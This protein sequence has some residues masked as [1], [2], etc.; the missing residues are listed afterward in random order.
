MAEASNGLVVIGENINTTRRIRAT[1]K[2]IVQEDGKV[3]WA[4]TGLDGTKR[5]LDITDIYPKD[6]K[7]VA[8]KELG[9]TSVLIGR[10]TRYR[11]REGSAAGASRAAS[12]SFDV[13]LH[14]APSGR[15]LWIGKFDE[16]QRPLSSGVFRVPS[17]P[18]GGTRW[19]SAEEMATWGAGEVA[20]SLTKTE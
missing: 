10:V 20:K 11:D 6:P 8:A 4:Y 2:N 17:Y 13:A 15:R 19:L 14:D 5:M 3:G 9:A 16:T 7:E 18:G 1:S 12:V